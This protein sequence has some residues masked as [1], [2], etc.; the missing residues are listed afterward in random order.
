MHL[1]DK[2]KTMTGNFVLRMTLG[3]CDKFPKTIILT[4]EEIEEWCVYQN[5]GYLVIHKNE[6]MDNLNIPEPDK[7]K[8]MLLIEITETGRN[9]IEFYSL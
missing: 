7:Y 6:R 3:R 1:P 8:N 9:I 2:N 4:R 5:M